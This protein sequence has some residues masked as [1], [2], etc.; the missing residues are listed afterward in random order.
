VVPAGVP[1]PCPAGE[2][3]MPTVR[4]SIVVADSPQRA[5]A[6]VAD[7]H[8]YGRFTRTLHTRLVSG[9][10]ADCVRQCSSADGIWTETAVDWIE[11][12]SY[13]M[14]VDTSAP[15]YPYPLR[16]LSGQFEVLPH[17]TG[18]RIR[19]TFRVRPRGLAGWLWLARQLRTGESILAI[20]EAYARELRS[21][22]DRQPDSREAVKPTT[23]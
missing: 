6:V 10:G 3:L 21:M 22:S 2:G 15:G 9:H 4:R 14:Q 11:G 23:P 20:L 1:P 16:A 19:L 17:G 8:G 5:W 7:V 18:S 12:R 13:T